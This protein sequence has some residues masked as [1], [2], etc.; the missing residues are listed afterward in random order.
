MSNNQHTYETLRAGD[1]VEITNNFYYPETRNTCY[2]L[3]LACLK[4]NSEH[5]F[6]YHL[7]DGQTYYTALWFI[8]FNKKRKYGRR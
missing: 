8:R 5:F 7:K 2:G 4:P 1:L 6:I 3:I